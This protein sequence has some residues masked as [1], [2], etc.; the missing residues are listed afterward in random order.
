MALLVELDHENVVKLHE[1]IPVDDKFYLVFEYMDMDMKRYLERY[2]RG[3]D[4]DVT[5][6]SKLSMIHLLLRVLTIFLRESVLDLTK[7]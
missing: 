1:I 6:V 2:P 7:S 5:R 4:L 3:L